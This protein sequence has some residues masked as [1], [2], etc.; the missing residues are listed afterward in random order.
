V[1]R[2]KA[3]VIMGSARQ[4]L[5]RVSRTKKGGMVTLGDTRGHGLGS[6]ALHT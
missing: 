4:G 1:I 2:G 5:R 3:S 6:F